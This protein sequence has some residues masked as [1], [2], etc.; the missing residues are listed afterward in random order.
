MQCPQC[1]H[2]NRETAKFCEECG[3]RLVHLCVHCGHAVSPRAKFCE[4]CGTP[5]MA[6]TS[7]LGPVQSMQ[8]QGEAESRLQAL[9]FAVGGLLQ[10]KRRVTYRT[11]TYIFGL[12]DVSLEAV[13]KEL[14]F[15]QLARDE[16]GEGL[17][18]MGEAPAPAPLTSAVAPSQPASV[19][20]TTVASPTIPMPPP[21]VPP[22]VPETNGPTASPEDPPTDVSPA[23]PITVPEPV[24]GAPEAEHRQL[25]V[26]FCDLADSTQL[27]T[28]GPGRPAR[29]HSGVSG[30]R[31]R[32]HPP[33]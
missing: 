16:E 19:D 32:H 31:R 30:H 29:G 14:L 25:T 24:R 21:C 3:A 33:V 27:S 23:E 10:G 26:M 6:T 2:A 18:W 7:D 9:V 15:T 8:Q 17:V 22:A 4:E 28:T 20:A 12:D 13:R 5:I 11:L 1:Q